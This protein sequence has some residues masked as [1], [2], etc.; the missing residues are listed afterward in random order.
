MSR[1][2]HDAAAR[3]AE[4]LAELEQ[5]EREHL[6]SDVARD[7]LL[8]LQQ[9]AAELARRLAPRTEPSAQHALRR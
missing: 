8:R 3:Y 1:A 2:A 7:G 9:R 4:K 5:R 6:H